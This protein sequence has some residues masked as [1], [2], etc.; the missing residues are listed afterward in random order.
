MPKKE[1][2]KE[3]CH[4]PR[5]HTPCPQPCEACEEECDP[6]YKAWV[7]DFSYHGITLKE[8]AKP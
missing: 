3:Y 7:T 2:L 1:R 8:P 6:K 4:D 5:H